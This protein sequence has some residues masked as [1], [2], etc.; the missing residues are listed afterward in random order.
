MCI[1]F[2]LLFCLNIVSPQDICDFNFTSGDKSSQYSMQLRNN[3]CNEAE[4]EIQL[5]NRKQSRLDYL[6]CVFTSRLERYVIRSEKA[7][8]TSLKSLNLNKVGIKK[9]EKSR[10]FSWGDY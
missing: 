10:V 4:R 1:L 2:T 7:L 3:I 8:N 6:H 9:V 5:I